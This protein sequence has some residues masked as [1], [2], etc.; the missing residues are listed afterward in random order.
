MNDYV[1]QGCDVTYTEN[2]EKWHTMMWPRVGI[3]EEHVNE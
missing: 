1:R 2:P 3:S